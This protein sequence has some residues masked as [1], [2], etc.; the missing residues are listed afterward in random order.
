M[1][2]LS[3]IVKVS[4]EPYIPLLKS[5]HVDKLGR[6]FV[7]HYDSLS[8]LFHNEY[9]LKNLDRITLE[10]MQE[11]P[12]VPVRQRKIDDDILL[13]SDVSRRLQNP[14]DV[15]HHM[16]RTAKSKAKYVA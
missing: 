7:L 3:P 1:A 8:L 4:V 9:A 6:K 15:M 14:A 10:G 2:K 16:V 13:N 11:V 12:N 5:E